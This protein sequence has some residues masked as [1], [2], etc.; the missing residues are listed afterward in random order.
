MSDSDGNNM[1]IGLSEFSKE[2]QRNLVIV[3]EIPDV[4]LRE[5]CSLGIDEAGRGPVL[6]KFIFSSI[7]IDVLP[8]I[9][10]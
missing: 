7:I 8:S 4:C 2:N 10:F 9:W 5:P 1:E 3:S 6:G